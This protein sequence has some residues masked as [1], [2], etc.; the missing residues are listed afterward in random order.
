MSAQVLSEQSSAVR[1]FVALVR[2]HAAVT[3]RLSVELTN[4]HGLTINDYE[5]LLRLAR[6]PDRRM[7][8]VDL[9]GEVLLTPSGIT[10]LLDGLERAG[11]VERGTCESDRRVV[12]AVLTDAGLAKVREA[13]ATHVAQIDELFAARLDSRE[14]AR[15]ADLMERLGDA[16]ADDDCRPPE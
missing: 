10:R 12:Y 14:L 9:A 4:D 13:S 3:R 5:V 11:F 1:A 8:R 7:R 2:S 16:A 15:I 6:A